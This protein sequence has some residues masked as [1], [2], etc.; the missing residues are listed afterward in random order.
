MGQNEF[1]KTVA[2]RGRVTPHHEDPT[3]RSVTSLVAMVILTKAMSQREWRWDFW[4]A[5]KA[6]LSIRLNQAES[7]WAMRVLE[8]LPALLL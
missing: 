8:G 4:K 5:Q 6:F 2:R 3:L 7:S 1:G